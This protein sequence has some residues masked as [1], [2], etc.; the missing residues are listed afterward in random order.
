MRQSLATLL[1]DHEEQA[2]VEEKLDSPVAPAPRSRTALRKAG[3]K[4]TQDNFP[5]HSFAT[6]L[7]D[8]ATIVKNKVK[9]KLPSSE[10]TFDKITCPTPVQQKALDLLGVNLLL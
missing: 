3:S 6:L 5:V 7:A 10:V 1:F 9:A 4:R 8:L 2:L